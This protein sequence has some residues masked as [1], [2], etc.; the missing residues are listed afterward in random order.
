MK[1]RAAEKRRSSWRGERR[2]VAAR[3]PEPLAEELCA[4]AASQGMTVNEVL[5]RAVA[6]WIGPTGRN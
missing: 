3:L 6:A 5:T 4:L 1:Q 2:F